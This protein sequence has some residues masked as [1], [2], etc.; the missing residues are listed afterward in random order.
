MKTLETTVQILNFYIV[1]YKGEDFRDDCTDLFSLLFT[2]SPCDNN[3]SSSHSKS[4][5]IPFRRLK[6]VKYYITIDPPFIFREH[7][8]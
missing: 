8:L 7:S 4:S 6:K 1:D 2:F 3:L 5:N